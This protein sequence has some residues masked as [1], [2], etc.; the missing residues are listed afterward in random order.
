[1]RFFLLLFFIFSLSLR[2]SANDDLQPCPGC[3]CSDGLIEKKE[4]FKTEDNTT[5]FLSCFKVNEEKLVTS[6]LQSHVDMSK[7]CDRCSQAD[8][9]VKTCSPEKM[10]L[11]ATYD[12]G[13]AAPANCKYRWKGFNS[14]EYNNVV[15]TWLNKDQ[16]KCTPS[17]CTS[18]A[19]LA[20]IGKMKSLVSEGKMSEAD[21]KANSQT[22][23]LAFRILNHNA[24]P[25]KLVEELKIGS[26]SIQYVAENQ[27]GTNGVP[28]KGDLVQLWRKNNSGH[29]AVFKGFI[30]TDNDGKPDKI[31]FWSSQS[32]T[33]GYGNS[34]EDVD[35]IDRVLIGSFND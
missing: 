28:K 4:T 17:M 25:N 26:G 5:E 35:K 3:Q 31:C 1:M 24:E 14:K 18:A 19:F 8:L 12:A 15:D 34:C 2:A 20:V 11:P 22:T 10:Y 21:L 27:L 6:C 30:D 29:S 9:K 13:E 32:K 23:S 33:N 7:N 16:I